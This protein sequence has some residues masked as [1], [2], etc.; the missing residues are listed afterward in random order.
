MSEPQ[1]IDASSQLA[2]AAL[3]VPARGRICRAFPIIG[4]ESAYSVTCSAVAVVLVVAAVLKA[5]ALLDSLP[6]TSPR[7]TPIVLSLVAVPVEI[8]VAVWL[9]SGLAPIWARRVTLAVLAA[10]GSV[11][12]WHLYRGDSDCGCLGAVH[13]GPA[14]SVAFDVVAFCA[15]V[16]IR[17]RP[18]GA[19]STTA[20]A[21]PYVRAIVVAGMVTVALAVLAV[22]HASA[23]STGGPLAS[24][25][26]GTRTD[27]RLGNV[28]SADTVQAIA[29]VR[30]SGSEPI[31]ILSAS[32]DCSCTV[33]DSPAGKVAPH[34]TARIPVTIHTRNL[35]NGPFHKRLMLTL[36]DVSG[37]RRNLVFT[38]RGEI[39]RGV[40]FVALS[41]TINFAY[42]T[43]GAAA[44]YPT[45]YFYASGPR[46]L[47]DEL[48][49]VIGVVATKPAIIDIGPADGNREFAVRRVP[50]HLVLDS[51][52]P[53]GRL[54]SSIQVRIHGEATDT[55]TIP[56]VATV[57][58]GVYSRPASVLLP[59]YARQDTKTEVVVGSADGKPI[60]VEGVSSDLPVT[61]SVLATGGSAARIAVA[62]HAGVLTRAAFPVKGLLTIKTTGRQSRL[63]VPVTLINIVV[64][65]LTS[66]GVKSVHP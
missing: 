48:P 11:A 60:Q 3:E 7:S 53:Q 4:R 37:R 59:C 5:D 54:T 14:W 33:A 63:T 18:T 62:V 15:I 57:T 8:F 24:A 12:A 51:S 61:C 2:Q 28:G 16:W 22:R 45:A 21:S 38:L 17:R 64:P 55:V 30:N 41:S 42:V 50:V 36:G 35:S 23:V 34:G 27:I 20:S 6:L 31:A 56:V 43:A 29:E 10:L 66:E 9:L 44:A 25:I 46:S 52:A 39:G 65:E 49:E 32:T 58:N 13:A 1:V 26:S 47:I 40:Q 19:R